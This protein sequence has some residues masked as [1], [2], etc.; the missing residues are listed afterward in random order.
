MNLNH[1]HN[2]TVRIQPVGGSLVG[3]SGPCPVVDCAQDFSNVCPPNLVAKGK[4][5][6]YVGC[7]SACDASFE[8]S[9][10]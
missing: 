6:R 1:G 9:K 7:L 5:G 2:V 8:V 3:G 4:D 10:T